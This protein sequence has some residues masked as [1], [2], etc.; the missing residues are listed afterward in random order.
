MINQ[1]QPEDTATE[2]TQFEN[3]LFIN[4]HVHAMGEASL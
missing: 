4:L 2:V 1:K 3:F